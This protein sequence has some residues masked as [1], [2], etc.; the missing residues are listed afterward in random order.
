MTSRRTTFLKHAL[1]RLN[2]YAS[3]T[4]LCNRSRLWIKRLPVPVREANTVCVHLQLVQVGRKSFPSLLSNPHCQ[5]LAL[6]F[7]RH[8]VGAS[9]PRGR[10]GLGVMPDKAVV[11]VKYEAARKALRE[12]KSVDEVKQ[13]HDEAAAMEA[14]ARI[15]KDR[16]LE[17]IAIDLR[18]RA[19]RGLGKIMEKQRKTIGMAKPRSGKGQRKH[20]RR[21]IDKPDGPPTLA[22]AGID[23]NLAHA[24]RWTAELTEKEFE[25]A[26]KDRQE[27]ADRLGLRVRRR[28][29]RVIRKYCVF[30]SDRRMNCRGSPGSSAREL[31]H[32]VFTHF[33]IL[34]AVRR[35]T[36]R[37]L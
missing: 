10:T 32:A 27:R 25:A 33:A 2:S 6:R 20:D 9:G 18:L 14:Y 19:Q 36:S 37:S 3:R 1:R 11:P 34:A 24:A 22:E 26:V 12:A 4:R 35:R 5:F 30:S 17:N 31:L 8:V 15:A 13:I 7:V 29:A 28:P 23:K 16:E 21:V